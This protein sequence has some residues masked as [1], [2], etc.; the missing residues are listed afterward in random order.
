MTAAIIIIVVIVYS[1]AQQKTNKDN[2]GWIQEYATS[3][4]EKQTLIKLAI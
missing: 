4:P 1:P 2:N 3:L